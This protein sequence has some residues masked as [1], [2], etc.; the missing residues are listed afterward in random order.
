[1][2]LDTI[3]SVLIPLIFMGS[4]YFYIT[5][6]ANDFDDSCRSRWHR[7]YRRLVF[8]AGDVRRIKHFPWVTWD[9]SSHEID[10]R[11]SLEALKKCTAGCI[12]L[13]RDKGYLSNFAIPGFMKHAWIH[14]NGPDDVTNM[15]VVEAIS[16]GVVRRHA[17]YPLRSDY[18]II[19][20]P[21]NIISE[22]VKQAVDKA[23][24]V[25]G[26]KYDA[27]F[28]FDI[29]D[30]II[31]FSRSNYDLD[32]INELDR[33]KTNIGAEWDGGFSCTEVV[34]FC[35]W[36][37]R[38]NL[39]LFRKKSRGKMVILADQLINNGFEIV[40]MSKNITPSLAFDMGLGE[41][42]IEMIKDY[43]SLK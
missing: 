33:L 35:W 43:L 2:L 22:D 21:K 38:K 6:N 36:H 17:L 15:E 5:R 7:A 8:W 12:G 42:G 19:L 11:E 37:L 4:W 18:V 41:E 30:E 20:K 28:E 27:N 9:I 34:C 10:I 23:N 24:M 16:E 26:C 25:V 31:H 39:Q 29:E 40:W 3:L 14:I 13:H 1:M 32:D